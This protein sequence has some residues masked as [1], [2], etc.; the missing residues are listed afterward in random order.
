MFFQRVTPHASFPNPR[1]PHLTPYTLSTS[2]SSFPTLCYNNIQHYSCS[3]EIKCPSV[4]VCELLISWNKTEL[5]ILSNLWFQSLAFRKWIFFLF[6]IQFTNTKGIFC[7]KGQIGIAHVVQPHTKMFSSL[8][9]LWT[10]P[11]LW[12]NARASVISLAHRHTSPKTS[13]FLVFLELPPGERRSD[14]SSFL[15]TFP[16]PGSL[17]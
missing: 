14:S 15:C 12:M 2:H 17:L 4:H 7:P 10:T 13:G 11:C 1:P 3:A 9:S 8:R 16:I 6:F 5:N